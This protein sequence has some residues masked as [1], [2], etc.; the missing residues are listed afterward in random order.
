[1]GGWQLEFD[2]FGVPASQGSKRARPVYAS[3]GSSRVFTGKVAQV[4]SSEHLKPWRDDVKAAALK[5]TGP[6]W[7]LVEGAV[8]L[9]VVFFFLRP[10]SH[11]RTGKNCHLLR[12]GAPRR[13]V[14]RMPDIDKTVR[15]VMDALSNVVYRDDRQVVLLTALKAYAD[16]RRPGAHVLIQGVNP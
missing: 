14:A 2:V 11:F 12:N 1:M 5:A 10:Q 13:Y 9:N 8:S 4:E 16:E 15:G 7:Q 6:G 3:K